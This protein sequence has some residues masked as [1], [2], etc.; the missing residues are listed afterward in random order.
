M[1]GKGDA[2]THPEERPVMGGMQTL[3]KLYS[4]LHLV[5]GT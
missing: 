5:R 1:V 4:V 3:V 2:V